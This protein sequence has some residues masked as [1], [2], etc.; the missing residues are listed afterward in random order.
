[1]K[2]EDHKIIYQENDYQF[3]LEPAL[4][5]PFERKIN[6]EQNGFTEL[7]RNGQEDN[8]VFNNTETFHSRMDL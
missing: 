6:K 3:L 4:L 8:V 7:A 5:L 2:N 1:M